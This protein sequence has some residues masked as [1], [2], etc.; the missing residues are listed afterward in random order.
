MT[1]LED[2]AIDL[3]AGVANR[4][5]LPEYRQI[6]LYSHRKALK[7]A[8][9]DAGPPIPVPA[10]AGAC[11][12]FLILDAVLAAHHAAME[13]ETSWQRYRALP[14][15]TMNEKLVAE[16][17]RILRVARLVAFHP[18]GHVECRNG[19]VKI[20][21]TVGKD[22][23]S[24]EITEAGLV[25]LE[26]AVVYSLE[27]RRQ[28]YPD[29][30]VEAVLTQYYCDIVA[31]VRRFFDE[32]RVLYQFRQKYVFNRHFRFDCD[33]PRLRSETRG[34]DDLIEIEIAAPYRDPARYPIDFFV[35]IGSELH[36]IPVE[37]LADGTLSRAALERWRIRSP[38][39]QTL[40]AA[41]RSRFGREAVAVNQP[42]S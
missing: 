2:L 28:P 19:I 16:L 29:A 1:L 6:E 5:S 42:M 4:L 25:L 12:A 30:Y 39:G 7:F 8:E 20:N 23:V 41:F 36:I 14:R 10:I 15:T 11:R 21:A 33:N 13:G 32:D 26:S 9:A 17:Y 3:A 35:M 34:D 24:L 40:P 27:S 37:A 38:D 18:K 31:E 22:A